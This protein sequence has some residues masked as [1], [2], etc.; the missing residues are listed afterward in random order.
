MCVNLK[1][2]LW[3]KIDVYYNDKENKKALTEARA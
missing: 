1:D 3:V 2:E